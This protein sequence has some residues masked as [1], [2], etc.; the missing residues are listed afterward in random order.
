MAL[1]LGKLH[2][3]VGQYCGKPV[4]WMNNTPVAPVLYALT[5][6]PGGQRPWDE[7]PSRN[8]A[9]FRDAGFELFKVQL[10][11]N[12]IWTGPDEPLQIEQAQ[13]LIRGVLELCPTAAIMLRLHINAPFW[14]NAA[15]PEEC[16]QYA[17]GPAKMHEADIGVHRHII[18][19][20]DRRQLHSLASDIWRR[21]TA[22]VLEEFCRRLSATPEGDRL[23]SIQFC[24]GVSHEW[25]YWGFI[26]HEPDCGPAMTRYFQRWLKEKYGTDDAIRKA[27]NDNAVCLA[28]AEVP[29][30]R[31]RQKWEHQIFRDL[32][33]DQRIVDYY[34]CQ[35]ES[36]AEDIAFFAA[37][38][39]RCWP[40]DIVIGVFY[41]YY[42]MMFSRQAVG[43]HLC[44]ERVL[45][46]PAI[47][48]LS[49]PFSYYGTSRTLGGTGQSRGITEACTIRGKLW[50][51]EQDQETRIKEI[52]TI[53]NNSIWDSKEVEHFL[54][55]SVPADISLIRRNALQPL[56]HQYG[57]W[58][59]DFGPNYCGGWW[60]F[61]AYMRE[62]QWLKRFADERMCLTVPVEQK[63]P[64]DVLVVYDTESY[65]YVYQGYSP[66]SQLADDFSNGMYRCGVLFDNAY[67]CDLPKMD[68]RQYKAVV[69]VNCWYMHSSMR[70]FVREKVCRD[71]RTVF[72][73]YMAGYLDEGGANIAHVAELAG[74]D[75]RLVDDAQ[76]QYAPLPSCGQGETLHI[77]RDACSARVYS[78]IPLLDENILRTMFAKAGAHVYT[79]DGIS[80]FG[81]EGLLVACVADASCY[82]IKLR[83]GKA[84]EFE[85]QGPLTVVLDAVTGEILRA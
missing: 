29:D 64:A 34:T 17:D 73:Q 18:G 27:W 71:G 21:D 53:K 26:E 12:D 19:D 46:C 59:F 40:R 57:F 9:L 47:D 16:T 55:Q 58:Y 7:I 15:H 38:F 23:F 43:G 65:Y 10:W 41:G 39:K 54:T 56:T 72:F 6:T 32:A 62:I 14:W 68:L 2:A 49:A 22:K 45:D 44:M 30:M 74:A 8:I 25:H 20:L 24:D 69:F 13:K 77:S 28:T 82:T 67:L 84:V 3:K 11:L 52:S 33:S 31:W 36:V 63:R 83:N 81:G 85:A 80:L 48:F 75:V 35:Q 60:D 50:M 4:F 78:P 42:F 79:Q 70:A 51:S 61:P 66:I 5:D 1:P 37:L 76:A